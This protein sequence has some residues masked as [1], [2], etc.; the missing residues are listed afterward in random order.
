MRPWTIPNEVL[1][2][3]AKGIRVS[4]G[5]VKKGG[6]M[7]RAIIKKGKIQPIDELPQH[8][9]EGQELIV[10]SCAPSDDPADIKRW[11]DELVAL[12]AQIPAEDHQRMSVAIAEQNRQAKKLMRRD[13]GFN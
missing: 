9:R 12:S 7:I 8:W 2:Q 13:L 11:H 5:T 4:D 1:E 6:P 10:E 3:L